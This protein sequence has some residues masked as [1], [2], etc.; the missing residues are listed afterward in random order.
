MDYYSLGFSYYAHDDKAEIAEVVKE[1]ALEQ[2]GIREGDVITAIG[3]T[4]I[5]TGKELNQYFDSLPVTAEPL[6]VTYLHH[7]VEKTT[8]VYPQAQKAYRLGFSYN[9]ENE[10]TGVGGVLKYSFAEMR[11]QLLS[12]FKSLGFLISGKGSLDMLSGPVGIVEV[13][14]T[15]YDASVSS[16][17]LATLTNMLSIMILLSAN[18]GVINL[19]P[20]PALDGGKFLL[21]IIEAIRRKPIPNKYEGIITMVGAVLIMLLA[22]VVLVNDVIKLF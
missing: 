18:L 8:T 7:G 3:D 14:G 20:I 11:Y 9:L 1:G 19:L 22:A 17:F 12:V 21:L 4:K 2:A 15:T 10:K 5:A 16:G 13:I 6:S